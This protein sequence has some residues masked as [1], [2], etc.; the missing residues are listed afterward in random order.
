MENL[1][2]RKDCDGFIEDEL[3]ICDIEVVRHEPRL[4]NEVPASLTGK[5]GLFTF[6]RGWYYWMVEGPLPLPIARELYEHPIGR[7]VVRVSGH[8]ASPPPE[9]WVTW[10]LP[11]GRK[12]VPVGEEAR[13][14][15]LIKDGFSTSSAK[16]KYAFSDNP[17]SIGAVAC[18]MS[19]H[20]DTL[21]GLKLFADTLRKHGLS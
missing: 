16:S 17:E 15:D 12:V 2:G 19:Y 1:A 7:Q 21:R 3:V 6:T 10:T 9:E 14:D 20:I 13:F 4:K 11:D 8:C 18:V 5:L